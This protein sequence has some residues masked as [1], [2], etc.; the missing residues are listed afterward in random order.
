M[1][2]SPPN[3][4]SV[5][6]LKALHEFI[7]DEPPQQPL[8]QIEA[9]L[10]SQG[11][12]TVKMLGQIQKKVAQAQNRLRLESIVVEFGCAATRTRKHAYCTIQEL[13]EAVKVMVSQMPEFHPASAFYS[14]L[15]TATEEDLESLLSDFEELASSIDGNE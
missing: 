12:D 3:Q 5:E 1:S 13:R 6:F 15:E 8:E 11:V 4:P 9:R 14:K 2:E 7:R 10:K